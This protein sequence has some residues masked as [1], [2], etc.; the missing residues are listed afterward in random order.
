[1]KLTRMIKQLLLL[2]CVAPVLA[3]ANESSVQLDHV[4][5][6]P[7]NQESLQRG[8]QVFVNYCL[9]CHSAQAMRFNGLADIGIPEEQIKANMLFAADKVTDPMTV[10]MN[11]KEAKEWFGAVPPDLSVI[12]RTKDNGADWLYTYLRGF[13]RDS[14]R[15]TGWNNKVFDKVGMPHVLWELQGEQVAVYKKEKDHEGKEHE[16]LEK[17]E[18]VKPGLLTSLNDGKANTLEYDRKVTD[19][20]N[21][22]VWMGEPH[23]V[24]RE[25]LGYGVLFF[26][27]LILLPFVYLLKQDYWKEV[28]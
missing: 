20:V 13:Y 28:H 5:I 24:F 4:E 6:N 8:A 23:Q 7:R 9:S 18:L 14:S 22:L 12:A 2:A 25:Q 11:G 16:V 10:A 15:P 27:I 26:L 19:L 21:Y 3:L 17:L 1:M